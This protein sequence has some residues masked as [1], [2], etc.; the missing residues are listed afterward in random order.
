MAGTS[1]LNIP[2]RALESLV[3]GDDQVAKEASE[4]GIDDK[5]AYEITN[6][7]NI[8]IAR[9]LDKLTKDLPQNTEPIVVI[10]G[11]AHPRVIQSYVHNNILEA[12]IK[13]RLYKPFSIV[14]DET[15]RTYTPENNTWVLKS[16]IPY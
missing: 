5:L 2:L 4:Y 14:A 16:R 6:Y 7:R 12:K 15:A 13:S 1:P 8:R 11:A 3:R 10:Y 9:G